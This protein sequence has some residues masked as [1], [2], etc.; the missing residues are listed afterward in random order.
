MSLVFSLVRQGGHLAGGAAAAGR[1]R[2][3]GVGHL[4]LDGA[5]LEFILAIHTALS[6]SIHVRCCVGAL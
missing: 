4:E 5:Y 2:L 3:T 1:A 6:V